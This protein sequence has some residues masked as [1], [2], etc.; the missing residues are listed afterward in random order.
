MKVAIYLGENSGISF[1]LLIGYSQFDP[2]CDNPLSLN[3][4]SCPVVMLCQHSWG[5]EK[6]EGKKKK[7]QGGRVWNCLTLCIVVSLYLIGLVMPYQ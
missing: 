2:N 5:E 3:G 6:G 4:L 1:L 7:G